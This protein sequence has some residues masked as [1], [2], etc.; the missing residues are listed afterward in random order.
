M[1]SKDLHSKP[2]TEETITKLEIFEKDL[3][4]WLPVFIYSNFKVVNICDFFAGTGKDVNGVAGSPL[5]ILSVIN[6]YE[7]NILQKNFNIKVLYNEFKKAKFSSLQ[8]N[9]LSNN[10]NK[11]LIAD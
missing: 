5:R 7:E 2:F 11:I 9:C 6:K 4:E 10:F 1:F 8:K 3:E